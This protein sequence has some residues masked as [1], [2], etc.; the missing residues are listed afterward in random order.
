MVASLGLAETDDNLER[1]RILQ[2]KAGAAPCVALR[3][4]SGNH[5]GCMRLI[6]SC[7]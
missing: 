5:Q 7:W 1:I 6:F 2:D 3:Q 4:G